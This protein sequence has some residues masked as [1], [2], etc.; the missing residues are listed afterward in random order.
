MCCKL[1]GKHITEQEES[2]FISYRREP[3]PYLEQK[4]CPRE[5]DHHTLPRG[6]MGLVCLLHPEK[7]SRHWRRTGDSKESQPAEIHMLS[8]GEKRRRR[9]KK[10]LT[11]GDRMILFL[12]KEAKPFLPGMVLHL[13]FWWNILEST[14]SREVLVGKLRHPIATAFIIMNDQNKQAGNASL[15]FSDIYCDRH[16][17]YWSGYKLCHFLLFS[18]WYYAIER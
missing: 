5:A 9:R 14:V 18:C 4:F 16:N 12:L 8:K 10:E 11:A 1:T 7:I 15:K 13:I 6:R 2:C 3:A 17:Y